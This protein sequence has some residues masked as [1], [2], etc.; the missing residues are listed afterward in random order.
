MNTKLFKILSFILIFLGI[1][2]AWFIIRRADV[3]N[4]VAE[5]SDVQDPYG[6]DG[7]NGNNTTNGGGTLNEDGTITNEDG[8]TE[9]VDVTI[10]KDGSSLSHIFDGSVS[11]ATFI[12]EQR[13]IVVPETV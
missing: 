1:V 6:L 13:D 3:K 11:G 8:G 12:T 5:N 10:I 9:I 4:Q 2:G 7:V